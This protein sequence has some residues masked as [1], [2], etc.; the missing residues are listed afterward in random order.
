MR[1]YGYKSSKPNITS[2]LFI[3]CSA[4][5]RV[6]AHGTLTWR[7]RLV[8]FWNDIFCHAEMLSDSSH[9]NFESH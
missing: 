7:G 6:A 8:G 2:D 3:N 1:L 5:R 4:I 9:M